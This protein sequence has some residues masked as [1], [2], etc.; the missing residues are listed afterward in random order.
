MQFYADG[1]DARGGFKS[2]SKSQQA[3]GCS[4]GGTCVTGIEMPCT[5]KDNELVSM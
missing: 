1:S 4:V 2:E 5:A 3:D